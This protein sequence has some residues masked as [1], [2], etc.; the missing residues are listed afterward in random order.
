MDLDGDGVDGCTADCNDSDPSVAANPSGV[1]DPIG[2]IGPGEEGDGGCK[3]VEVPGGVV[4]LCL[5]AR[6]WMEASEHCQEKGLELVSIHD[7]ATMDALV[8]ALTAEFDEPHAN[9]IRS[10]IGLNDRKTEGTFEW[11]D[12]SAVDFLDCTIRSR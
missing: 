1:C 11:A 2:P 10:W 4:L 5:E 9:L 7:Q 8:D 12:G 3:E 6:P